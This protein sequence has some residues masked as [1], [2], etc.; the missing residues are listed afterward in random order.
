MHGARWQGLVVGSA[1]LLTALPAC[2][3]RLTFEVRPDI[4]PDHIVACSISLKD[5]W[6][7]LVQVQGYGMP[8]PQPTRWRTTVTEED[9]L[10]AALRSFV[11]GD[12]PSVDVY[13]A[14]SPEPPFVS[15]TWMTSLNG[16]LASGLYLQRGLN[17]TEVLTQS[18]HSLGLDRACGLTAK[19]AE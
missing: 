10:V 18:L 9:A 8:A 17:L 3:N 5:G 15:V 13:R 7:S 19:A 4:Q 1:V 12:A 11:T 6:I 16:D 14:R 2:A